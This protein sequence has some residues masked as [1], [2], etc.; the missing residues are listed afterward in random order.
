MQ[1]DETRR[2]DMRINKL[3]FIVGTSVF[4]VSCT[5]P[6]NSIQVFPSVVTPGAREAPENDTPEK[7]KPENIVW[8]ESHVDG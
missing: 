7:V 4:A 3:L 1:R 5:E 6:S 2:D 8:W